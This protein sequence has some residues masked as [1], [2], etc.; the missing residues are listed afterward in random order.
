MWGTAAVT[1]FFPTVNFVMEVEE[2]WWRERE[3]ERERE[4]DIDFLRFRDRYGI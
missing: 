1:F 4:R 2:Q 3:R